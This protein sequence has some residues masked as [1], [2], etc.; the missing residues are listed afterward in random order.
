MNKLGCILVALVLLIP[1]VVAAAEQPPR[2][3]VLV[4]GVNGSADKSFAPRKF[5]EQDARNLFEVFND[6]RRQPLKT[7]ARLLLG[8]ADDPAG[9]A[10]RANI[11]KNLNWLVDEAAADDQVIVV[12][13]GRAAPLAGRTCYITANAAYEKLADTGLTLQ[14]MTRALEKLASRHVC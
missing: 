1:G 9:L 8:K 6:P 11:L 7:E 12:L 13:L 14:E 5:A 2:T 10:T 3:F 4:V